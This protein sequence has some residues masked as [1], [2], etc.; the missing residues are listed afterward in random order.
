VQIGGA[1]IG[2]SYGTTELHSMLGI[3]FNATHKMQQ[4][5]M[6]LKTY[7]VNTT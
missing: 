6:N 4:Q 3:A 5:S 2:V 1:I 7:F